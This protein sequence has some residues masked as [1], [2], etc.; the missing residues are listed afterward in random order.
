MSFYKY[1]TFILPSLECVAYI[2]D[3]YVESDGCQR[4]ACSL[5]RG[6]FEFLYRDNAE[7]VGAYLPEF[8]CMV[9]VRRPP[10]LNEAHPTLFS[11]T[12]WMSWRSRWT[13]CSTLKNS[14]I[15]IHAADC[16]RTGC[17]PTLSLVISLATTAWPMRRHGSCAA[18]NVCMLFLGPSLK[19]LTERHHVV[20]QNV[21]LLFNIGIGTF[22]VCSR[23][24]Q[25]FHYTDWLPRLMATFTSVVCCKKNRQVL[26]SVWHGQVTQHDF[27]QHT[28]RVDVSWGYLLRWG[29]LSL[30]FPYLLQYSLVILIN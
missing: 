2:K 5:C 16:R 4:P 26:A 7:C 25:N 24:K 1:G 29:Q 23:R 14:S 22:A 10:T 20:A 12:P 13:P 9:C 18:Q 3:P 21:I 15:W 17:F 28:S 19:S 27:I 8:H 6:S 11:V 30:F